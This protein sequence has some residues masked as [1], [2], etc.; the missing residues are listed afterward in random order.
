MAV[1]TNASR[2]ERR[3]TGINRY[4]SEKFC[5]V[6]LPPGVVNAKINTMKM[7][8]TTNSA[9]QPTYGIEKYLGFIASLSFL[10]LVLK[11]G[12]ANF[13]IFFAK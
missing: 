6:R 1:A 13:I 2:N 4:M 9:I 3:K 10:R 11:L 8:A 5:K 12:I 7:G